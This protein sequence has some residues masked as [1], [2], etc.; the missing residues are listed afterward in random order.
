LDQ[1]L[2]KFIT[3][4]KTFRHWIRPRAKKKKKIHCANSH[5]V[6]LRSILISSLLSLHLPSYTISPFLSTKKIALVSHACHVLGLLPFFDFVIL[7]AFRKHIFDGT[8][9]E[10][11]DVRKQISYRSATS[12]SDRALATWPNTQVTSVCYDS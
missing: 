9:S 11:C 6:S 10:N 1:F 7:T 5:P 3:V 8:H 12:L 4:L 2:D